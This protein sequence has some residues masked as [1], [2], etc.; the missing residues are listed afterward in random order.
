VRPFY[1]QGQTILPCP[2]VVYSEP[3]T[4]AQ[5]AKKLVFRQPAKDGKR[6]LTRILPADHRA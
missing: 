2:L 6:F 1:I 5:V 4:A 3:Y